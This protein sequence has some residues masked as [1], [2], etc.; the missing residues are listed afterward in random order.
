MMTFFIACAAAGGTVMVLQLILTLVG[1]AGDHDVGDHHLAGDYADHGSS[2]FFG[3]LSFRSVVAAV[4]FFGLGGMVA[5]SSG[6]PVYAAVLVG[7][8]IGSAAM[9]LVAWLMRLLHTL[10]EAGNVRIDSA[11]GEMATV[12]LSIPGKRKGA[13]KVT[14]RLQNRTMEYQAVTAGDKTLPTGARV[15]VVGIV[16]SDTL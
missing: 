8:G 12:Y 5:T 6:L 13:G 7:C 1:L 4:T 9:V 11:V 2:V 3:I 16:G 15:V 14:V 10:G